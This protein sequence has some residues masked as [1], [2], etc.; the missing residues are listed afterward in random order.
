MNEMR[1]PQ[2]GPDFRSDN[3][4]AVAPEII[5]ALARANRDT[6]T[7]YGGDAWSLELQKRFGEL[8]EAKV[9]VYPVATGTAANALAMAATRGDRH[10]S[11]RA[12]PKTMVPATV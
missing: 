3:V 2:H 6:A 1:P 9:K 11:L 10:P 4:G 7:G 5:E 12:S 8:F